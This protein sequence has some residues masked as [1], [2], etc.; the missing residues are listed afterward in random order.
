MALFI[1]NVFPPNSDQENLSFHIK[2]KHTYALGYTCIGL[3]FKETEF[4][5][6]T[7]RGLK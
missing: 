1:F 2:I 5:G 3:H 7:S 4:S 6:L